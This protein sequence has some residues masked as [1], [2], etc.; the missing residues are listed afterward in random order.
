[1]WVDPWDITHRK[2]IVPRHNDIDAQYVDT[3]TY[4][5]IDIFFADTPA[6]ALIIIADNRHGDGGARSARRVRL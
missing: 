1:M 5:G 4:S 3:R 2:R 6:A